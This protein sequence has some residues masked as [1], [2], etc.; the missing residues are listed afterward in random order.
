[1][2]VL[3]IDTAT[4]VA[5]AA[6][7]GEERLIAD[8]YIHNLKT[9]SQII[10]PM[11]RQVMD[12]AGIKPHD[13]HGIAVTGG[14]GSFTG[15]RIGMSVAKTMGL[16]L[17]IPVMGIPTLELLAWNLYRVEGLICPI[18]DAKKNEVYTCIYKSIDSGLEELINPAALSIERLVSELSGYE[19]E[20]VNFLGDGV[21]VFGDIIRE[22]LGSRALFGTMINSFP[23]A[24]AVAELGLRQLKK[25]QPGDST[26]LQPV[27]LRKSEAELTWEQKNRHN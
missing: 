17:K 26:F 2:F 5:G 22:K 20:K 13:L 14:P 23:R 4:K 1:M 18:L 11:I 24:A 27:Y 6:V 21:P 25:E 15:L 7:V 16:A 12:D 9:H 3:G 10:I 8:R 19:K